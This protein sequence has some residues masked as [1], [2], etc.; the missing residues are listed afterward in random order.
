MPPAGWPKFNS[1]KASSSIFVRW[2]T[3][4]PQRDP[5]AVDLRDVSGSRLGH[6]RLELLS[7]HGKHARRAVR[8]ADGETPEVRAADHH[9][10]GAER[11]GPVDVGA[12]ADAA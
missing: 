5:C 12:G 3:A 2:L 8:S 6:H 10:A 1:D 4:A 7:D 9:R 11:Q